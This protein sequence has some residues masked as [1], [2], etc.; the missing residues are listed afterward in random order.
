MKLR[1]TRTHSCK[2]HA[3]IRM[4]CMKGLFMNV[5]GVVNRWS[6]DDSVKQTQPDDKILIGSVKH[7]VKV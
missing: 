5:S 1:R 2:H 4:K 3:H 6:A 7:A